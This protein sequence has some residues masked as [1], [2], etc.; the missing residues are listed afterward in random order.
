MARI[1]WPPTE[2]SFGTDAAVFP[3]GDNGKEFQAL[4]DRGMT[5]L[6]AIRSATINCAKL[7]GVEDRGSL[8]SRLMAD[9][10]GVEGNPLDDVRVLENVKFVM[11]GGKIFKNTTSQTFT[12]K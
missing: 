10:I 2:S 6:E 9:I 4:V 1:E 5:P 8:D 11:K 7:L 12:S 3:H